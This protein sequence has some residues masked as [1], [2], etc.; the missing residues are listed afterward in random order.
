MVERRIFFLCC[1]NFLR[2]NS[3]FGRVFKG[4]GDAKGGEEEVG[5]E[6]FRKYFVYYDCRSIIVDFDELVYIFFV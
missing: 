3:Y 4:L 2:N 6:L 5:D 1:R